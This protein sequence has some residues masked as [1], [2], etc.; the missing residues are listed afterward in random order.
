[1][2]QVTGDEAHDK[3]ASEIGGKAI[4]AVVGGVV[5]GI[6]GA[7]VAVAVEPLFVHLAAKSWDELSDVR[8]RSAGYMLQSASEQLGGPPEDVIARS[9]AA[10]NTAQLFADALQSAAST[11]NEEKIRALGRALANG[12]AGDQARV[13]EERLI[14]AGLSGLEAP[15]IR[16]LA[17]L[18]RQRSRP[19]STPTSTATSTAG[20]RG[21]RLAVVAE[22]S[23]LSVEGANNVI[24]E[25]TRTGMAVRDTYAAERRHDRY[26]LDLQAEVAKLQWIISNPGK[27]LPSNRRPKNLKKPGSVIEPGYERTP[28]GDVCLQY[29]E[30]MPAEDV[31]DVPQDVD[32]DSLDSDWD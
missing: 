30:S 16:L 9:F 12:L 21:V 25:L 24:S 23:G 11:S 4:A 5:G 10:E 7:L 32:D 6:P 2:D 19:T 27:R 28:F 8:R 20:R 3:T 14:V 1:M 31:I 15:H 13:D 29:L 18:P 26:I 22:A 17:L